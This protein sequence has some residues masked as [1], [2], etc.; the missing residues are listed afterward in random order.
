MRPPCA[1]QQSTD[2]LAVERFK[3]CDSAVARRE[4]P[5]SYGR[6]R[7][8][9]IPSVDVAMVSLEPELL[10]S[11]VSFPVL[12]LSMLAHTGREAAQHCS[13]IS[14]DA[15]SALRPDV[16]ITS[17]FQGQLSRAGEHVQMK[18]RVRLAQVCRFVLGG[19]QVR[20]VSSTMVDCRVEH[21]P[22]DH[23]AIST[24]RLSSF[25]VK[26]LY[27]QRVKGSFVRLELK[28]FYICRRSTAHP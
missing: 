26:F 12:V 8:V 23:F 27:S 5:A 6:G 22:S 14:H 17:R 3:S 24:L 15:Y 1:S 25:C 18:M 13:S 20:N 10:S 28:Y 7:V 16:S 11:S 19:G 4:V 2:T 21:S 9:S